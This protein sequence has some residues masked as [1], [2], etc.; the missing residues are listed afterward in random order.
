M[1]PSL[2]TIYCILPF[3]QNNSHLIQIL[4]IKIKT[5]AVYHQNTHSPL[6]FQLPRWTGLLYPQSTELAFIWG[7]WL[8]SHSMQKLSGQGSN[9][10]HSSGNV[11]S[12]TSCTTR[13]LPQSFLMISRIPGGCLTSQL[14]GRRM[15]LVSLSF[16]KF[17]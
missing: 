9:P 8:H 1:W 2:Q 13:E 17:A 12:L 6:T 15:T 14:A 16:T 7:G 5:A 3:G 4:K 11:R 10:S